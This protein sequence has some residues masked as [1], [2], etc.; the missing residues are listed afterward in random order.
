[1]SGMQLEKPLIVVDNTNTDP[2]EIAPY[3]KMAEYHDYE[4]EVITILVPI[5]VCVQRQTHGVPFSTLVRMAM[6]MEKRLP[7]FWNTRSIEPA[8][9]A[10]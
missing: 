7:G 8:Q 9:L 5:E 3:Y 10:A 6:N 4:A 2:V 1:M